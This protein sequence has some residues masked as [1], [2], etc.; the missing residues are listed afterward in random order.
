MDIYFFQKSGTTSG[1]NL[2]SFELL[3]TVANTGEATE[4]LKKNI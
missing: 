1:L 2:C 4:I 3:N